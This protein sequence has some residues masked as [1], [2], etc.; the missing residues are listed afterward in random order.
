M[1]PRGTHHG[2]RCDKY[3]TCCHIIARGP[4][5][6]LKNAMV[7]RQ[8][9]FAWNECV[10]F[11]SLFTYTAVRYFRHRLVRYWKRN[12]KTT[13]YWEMFT[14]LQY[15][16]IVKHLLQKLYKISILLVKAERFLYWCPPVNTLE[17][18]N[19]KYETRLLVSTL[20]KSTPLQVRVTS[21]LWLSSSKVIL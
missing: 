3:C 11:P 7:V 4:M 10:F 8:I 17:Q 2:G 14:S 12:P 9:N 18:V 13:V 20:A 5:I 6:I 16:M 1:Y 19:L 21:A 15:R